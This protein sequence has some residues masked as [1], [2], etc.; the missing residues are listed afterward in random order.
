MLCP[1]CGGI[2]DVIKVH[3]EKNLSKPRL[4]DV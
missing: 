3:S 1:K 2:Q 4:C